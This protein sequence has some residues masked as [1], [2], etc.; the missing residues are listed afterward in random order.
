MGDFPFLV[1]KTSLFRF[2]GIASQAESIILTI[3]NFMAVFCCPNF[4][5]ILLMVDRRELGSFSWPSVFLTD[6]TNVAKY[7]SNFMDIAIFIFH[8]QDFFFFTRFTSLRVLFTVFEFSWFEMN[9][10]T[11]EKFRLRNFSLGFKLTNPAYLHTI[12][13]GTFSSRS[14]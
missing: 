11:S 3:H 4:L 10:S 14:F 2:K 1:F 6:N 9:D 13:W 5:S 7:W 8:F 12:R